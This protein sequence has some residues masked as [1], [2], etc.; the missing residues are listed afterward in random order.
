MDLTTIENP[1]FL[2]DKSVEEMEDNFWL[3]WGFVAASARLWLQQVRLLS[4]GSAQASHGSGF[5]CCAAQA[6]GHAGFSS[7]SFQP[8]EHRLKSC[9]AQA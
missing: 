2:K 4:S 6:R 5:S 9:G 3:S 1:G 8:P 7:C